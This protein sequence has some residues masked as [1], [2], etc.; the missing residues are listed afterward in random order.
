MPVLGARYSL[1]AGIL[2][3]SAVFSLY[4][5]LNPSLNPLAI[6]N[7][8]LVGIFLCLLALRDGAVWGVFGWHSA[9]NWAQGNLFGMPVSGTFAGSASFLHFQP[10]GASLF[11]GG[12]FGPEGGLGVTAVL[13]FAIFAAAL[14]LRKRSSRSASQN[15]V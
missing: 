9:W 6:L 5:S 15:P 2:I 4:H 3:S 10:L 14:V 12:G 7:I 11:T 1:A 13:L 8:F